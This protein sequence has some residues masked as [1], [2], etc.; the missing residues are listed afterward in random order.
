MKTIKQSLNIL[1]DLPIFIWGTLF[2][3]LW[4]SAFVAGKI[5]VKFA[6]PF[7]LLAARFLLAS[8]ILFFMCWP[9]IKTHIL[10]DRTLLRDAIILGALNNIL[11]LGLTFTSLEYISSELV[12]IVASCAPFLTSIIA[13]MIGVEK[14]G[15]RT[16]KGILIGFCGVLIIALTRPIGDLNPFGLGTALLGTI[17]F[18]LATVFYRNRA[19]LHSPQQVNFWQSVIAAFLLIPLAI[20]KTAQ[21]TAIPPLL[22][23][24]AVIS[25]LA[26][27]VTICGMW[28]WLYLI[29]RAGATV[30]STYH[31]ANPFCGLLLSHFILGSE[32]KFTDLIGITTIVVGLLIVI[33]SAPLKNDNAQCASPV[34]R[35]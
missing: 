5:G 32:F 23:F 21:S 3:V 22:P 18:S 28:M 10:S 26:I 11:Y 24:T 1:L 4:S 33:R 6:D 7:T 12:I 29:R 20:Y 14:I 35:N 13:A 27:V 8:I 2:S 25:Y 31:L 16:I 34:T 17:A 30:A 9:A 19:G 15:M